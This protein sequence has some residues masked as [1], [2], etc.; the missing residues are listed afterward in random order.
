MLR[1]LDIKWVP[2][3]DPSAEVIGWQVL[4]KRV[5]RS[6][7]QMRKETI[8]LTTDLK[9]AAELSFYTRPMGKPLKPSQIQRILPEK[10]NGSLRENPQNT[11][12]G[13]D[14]LLVIVGKWERPPDYLLTRYSTWQREDIFHVERKR[15]GTIR[16]VT[17]FRLIGGDRGNSSSGATTREQ[18]NNP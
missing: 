2:K 7:Q 1:K 12:R 17:L 4:G 14:G 9:T 3:I 16:F 10:N 18:E 15:S 13:E 8:L 5:N 6:L 11:N